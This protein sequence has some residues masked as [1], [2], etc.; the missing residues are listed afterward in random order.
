MNEILIIGD[1]SHKNVDDTSDLDFERVLG[2]A[3]KN[4][5]KLLEVWLT[6]NTINCKRREPYP[7]L[8]V[9]PPNEMG[10]NLTWHYLM[11]L[12]NDDGFLQVDPNEVDTIGIFSYQDDP[13]HE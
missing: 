12:A 4:D 3:L 10:L 9:I 6:E 8:R 13:L 11:M 1:L 2:F 5:D 7:T